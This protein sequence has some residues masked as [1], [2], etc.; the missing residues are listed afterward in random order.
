MELGGDTLYNWVLPNNYRSIPFLKKH[1]Y[2]VL[3]LIE[4]RKRLLM[5]S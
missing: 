5:R 2:D 1:G 3:N 4:V